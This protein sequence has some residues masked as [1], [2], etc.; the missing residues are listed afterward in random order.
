MKFRRY[1]KRASLDASSVQ[2]TSQAKLRSLDTQKTHNS[3]KIMVSSQ[4]DEETD[5]KLQ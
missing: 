1:L 4:S 2:P 5:K 3:N